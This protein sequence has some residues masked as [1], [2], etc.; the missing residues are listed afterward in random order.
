MN[1]SVFTS[2]V[3]SGARGDGER[4]TRG[5]PQSGYRLK[6]ATSGAL[7]PAVFV[8]SDRVAFAP[9]VLEESSCC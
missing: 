4:R 9:L 5:V 1:F 8:L 6:A 7:S 2:E 3:D